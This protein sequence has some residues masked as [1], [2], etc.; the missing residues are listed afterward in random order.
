MSRLSEAYKNL[1]MGSI[2]GAEGELYRAARDILPLLPTTTQRLRREAD[3][4]EARDA[5]IQRLRDAVAAFEAEKTKS[6]RPEA[7]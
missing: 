4:I 1:K 3:E 6:N 5:A 7:E 2:K